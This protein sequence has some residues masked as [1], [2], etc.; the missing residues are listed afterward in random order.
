[1]FF[2]FFFFLDT[3]LALFCQ[4][5]QREIIKNKKFENLVK[6]TEMVLYFLSW[7]EGKIDSAL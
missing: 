5:T 7:K 4:L 3:A 6:K 2:Y 1:M